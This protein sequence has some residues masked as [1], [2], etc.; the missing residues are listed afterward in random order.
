[1]LQGRVWSGKGAPGRGRAPFL[2]GW[3]WKD[4]V[5]CPR[6]RTRRRGSLTFGCRRRCWH[7]SRPRGTFPVFVG[8]GLAGSILILISH[9]EALTMSAL[10]LDRGAEKSRVGWSRR[11]SGV[12]QVALPERVPQFGPRE[13]MV[14]FKGYI[15]AV[16]LHHA[17]DGA[18]GAEGVSANLLIG[19]M[20]ALEK[21]GRRVLRDAVEVKVGKANVFFHLGR[22]TAAARLSHRVA[23]MWSR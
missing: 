2:A 9:P 12:V 4:G 14:V 20:V 16:I 10:G 1:M 6:W 11:A 21:I 22:T 19:W 15:R 18:V 8:I 5:G 13:L 7:R 17:R 23:G 3:W